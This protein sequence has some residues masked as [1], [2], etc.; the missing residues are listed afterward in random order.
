ML[1]VLGSAVFGAASMLA[2]SLAGRWRRSF[3]S[4]MLIA[5]VSWFQMRLEARE[6]AEKLEIE[7]LARTKVVPLC[8]T[9]RRRR[10]SGAQFP[11]PV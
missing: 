7:E 9:P 5:F 11:R 1:L 2:G 3:R 10:F 4:G 8:S 6:A